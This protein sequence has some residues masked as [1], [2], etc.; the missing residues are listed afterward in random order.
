MHHKYSYLETLIN[1]A[2]RPQ[3]VMLVGKSYLIIGRYQTEV[4]S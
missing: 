1:G 2:A 4:T 3:L